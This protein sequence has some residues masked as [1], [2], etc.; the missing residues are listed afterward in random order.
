[1]ILDFGAAG[2][3]GE[4]D[5]GDGRAGCRAV[6]VRR[7]VGGI[8]GGWS[9]RWE[10]ERYKGDGVELREDSMAGTQLEFTSFL[11]RSAV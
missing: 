6:S 3:G 10:M 5:C 9:S 8:G 11:W 2:A 4:E 7:W 1:M